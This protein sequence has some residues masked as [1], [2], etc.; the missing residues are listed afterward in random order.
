LSRIHA[1]DLAQLALSP[2]APRG[3]TFVVGDLAPA[4]HIEVV[5]YICEAYRVPLPASAPIESLHAS[6]RA[7]R[8]IDP[9][10]ALRVLGVELRYPSYRQGM[11]P[12]ATGLSPGD[13]S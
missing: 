8:A 1:E 11:S 3:D 6:L 5:R 7:D 10:R 12:A 4:P 13:R 2:A 9:S